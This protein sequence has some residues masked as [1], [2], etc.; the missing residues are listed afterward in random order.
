MKNTFFALITLFVLL[1]SC[2]SNEK[3]NTGGLLPDATGGADELLVFMEDAFVTDSLVQNI[4]K[5]MTDMYKILPQS[6]VRFSITAVQYSKMNTILERFRNPIFVITKNE[7]SS[8]YKEM[9]TK[10]TDSEKQTLQN[11]KDA[12][13]FKNNLTA[14][15]QNVAIILVPNKEE[16]VSTLL[17]YKKEMF[18]FF[19]ENNLKFFK[20]V[21]Y[22]DGV[23]KTLNK[24]FKK[25]H[26]LKFD[27]PNGFVLAKNENNLVLLRKED[28][29]STLFLAI[30]VMEYNDTISYNNLGIEK[31]NKTGKLLDGETEGSYVVADTTLGF[32]I[33]KSLKNDLVIFENAGLW[34]MQNDYVGGGPFVN[35]YI[36][37]NK[38]KRVIYLQ[39]MIYGPGEKKK[40]KYMRQFEAMFSTLEILD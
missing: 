1:S 5:E 13:F 34:I 6:E 23:N 28:V 30:D 4:R 26:G 37:D 27:V 19:D 40:K 9:L 25:F 22:Y 32:D 35:Q 15:N 33:E 20:D 10:L 16:I 12:I 36:I 18:N 14:N 11:Q 3:P 2:N 7:T 39:A 17:K 8:L 21:A 29:K 24:Q 31:F 38:R